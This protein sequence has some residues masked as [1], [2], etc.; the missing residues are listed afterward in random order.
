MIRSRTIRVGVS[1]RD[2]LAFYVRRNNI[3]SRV[4][5]YS[6]GD[7]LSAPPPTKTKVYRFPVLGKRDH[8]EIVIG[9]DAPGPFEVSAYIAEVQG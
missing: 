6:F 1:V 2:T 7:D 3:T 5:P 8:P 4:E 9:S